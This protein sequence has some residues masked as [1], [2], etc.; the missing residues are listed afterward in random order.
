MKIRSL[1]FI[2][3]LCFSGLGAVWGNADDPGWPRWRGPNGDGISMETDWDPEAL[4]GGT[5]ILWKTN[6]GLG[7][8]NVAIKD[9]RLYTMGLKERK[10][11]VF[12]L[13]AETG[14]ELWRSSTESKGD[15][16][17]T[18]TIDGKY[19][20]A[21]DNE[22]VL[23]CLRARNGKVRWRKDLVEE[24][25]TEKIP[26]GYSGSPVIV[27]DLVILNVNTAGIALNKNTGDLVWVS[28]IHTDKKN[29]QG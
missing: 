10:P 22:G 7:F 3:F 6:I 21:L 15:P 12:C 11:T 20:Y 29:T 13:N 18:P 24:Y 8:S 26:Y 17:S 28:P 9:N 23:L 19:V 4:V 25:K 1:I 14:K 16:Q 5:K 2:L 27:D